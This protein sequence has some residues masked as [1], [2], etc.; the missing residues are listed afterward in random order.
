MRA[1]FLRARGPRRALALSTALG[2]LVLGG[3]TAPAVA[4]SSFEPPDLVPTV[5]DGGPL[6]PQ[7]GPFDPQEGCL[8]GNPGGRTIEE[9]PWS[10]RYL[11]FEQ[12][13]EQGL[14]G[15]GQKIAVI[16]TGVNRH[17]R[18]DVDTGGGSAVPDGRGAGFDC[19]GHGTAV[20]GIIAAQPDSQ[21]GFVGVAPNSTILSIRQSSQKFVNQNNDQTVGNTATM[22]QAVKHATEAGASVIN[23]SQS[24]C[25]A[26]AEATDSSSPQYSF[27]NQLHQAVKD[28]YDEGA[29]V[30]AAAGNTTDQCQKNPSGDPTTAVLPAWYDDYVLTVGSVNEQGAPSE[31]TV[32]GPWVDVAAPGENLTSLDPGVGGTG[33]ANQLQSGQGQPE[34]IMG[35][36]FAAPYVSGLVALI[37]QEHPELGPGQIMDRIE[38]TALHPGGADGRNDIVGAGVIDPMAAL[39]DVVP[40]EHGVATNNNQPARLDADVLP[41]RDWPALLTALGGTGAGIAAIVFTAF[42]INARRNL[43]ARLNAQRDT[44]RN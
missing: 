13:H 12:A 41:P 37:K 28:A 44:T 38:K 8:Q 39:N 33:L 3:P 27:N 42:L 25:Q 20:A 16:D 14:N 24:S 10:Q 35:T 18:L 22:A 43:R 9:K 26:I 40:A 34:P 11:G 2:V 5:V 29:V 7:P 31:F 30:V 19:D 15:Q 1:R 32:P 21:T 23:I 6:A 17:P 36:S 4:E